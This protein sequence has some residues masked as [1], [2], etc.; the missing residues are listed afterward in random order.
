MKAFAYYLS[1][2]LIEPVVVLAG[3]L[4]ELLRP[5]Y[6][7]EIERRIR[8]CI[9]SLYFA[10]SGVKI[11]HSVEMDGLSGIVLGNKVSLRSSSEIIAGSRGA[12]KV[13]DGTHVGRKS[14][15]NGSG[16]GVYIG[17]K[18]AISSHVSI[19]SVSVD[20]IGLPAVSLPVI[21]GDEVLIGMGVVVMPG[22]TVGD[23][24][25][26][27]AGSVVVR[28]VKAGETVVGVPAKPLI[29]RQT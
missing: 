8:G 10:S 29:V 20:Q 13:G 1:G 4:S 25:R 21:I 19:F 11:D 15:V 12:V 7:Y 28:D 17:K 22:V 6:R 27:G 24:A 5:N 14:I 23:G 2:I 9:Y 16:G 18:C 26:I 3:I